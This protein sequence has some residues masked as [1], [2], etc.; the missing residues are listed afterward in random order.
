MLNDPL[1]FIVDDNPIDLS[2]LELMLGDKY[3]VEASES[4]EEC[5]E[6]LEKKRPE[7]VLLDIEMG[8]ISG[9]EVCKKIK[10]NPETKDIHIIFVSGLNTQ[11]Q[12][13]AGFDVG[14]DDYVTKP[15]VSHELSAKIELAL[16][17]R[18]KL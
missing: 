4:G 5:L 7:L 11:E 15:F 8:G 1:I 9:L 14:A 18:I 6:K 17:C 13:K 3:Q 2:L 16:S 12:I 10:E